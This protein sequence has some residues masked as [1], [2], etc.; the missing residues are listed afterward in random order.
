MINAKE[1]E[2]A[3]VPVSK[4]IAKTFFNE[5]YGRTLSQKVE[6][7]KGIPKKDF[8]TMLIGGAILGTLV[9]GSRK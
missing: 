7:E 2:E 5:Q 9:L 4:W 8:H 6:D 3:F 1:V